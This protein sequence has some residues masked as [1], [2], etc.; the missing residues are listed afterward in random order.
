[1]KFNPQKV[2]KVHAN[3]F[4]YKL[5]GPNTNR[6][7]NK[8]N[9]FFYF[10]NHLIKPPPKTKSPYCRVQ[11]LLML[12]EFIFPLILMLGVAFSIYEMTMRFKC[13]HADKKG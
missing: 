10:Q 4:I 9:A 5:F 8:F 7:H 3:Y 12:M 13:H 6:H 1:M 2:D 11:P